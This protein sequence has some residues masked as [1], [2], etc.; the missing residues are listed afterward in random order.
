MTDPVHAPSE[1]SNTLTVNEEQYPEII[2]ILPI[3]NTVIFPSTMIPISVGRESS[4]KLIDE[5]ATG[6]RIVGCLFQ[7]D[8][9]INNPGPDDLFPIG[10]ICR[11]HKMFQVPSG[12]RNVVLQGLDRFR[13]VEYTGDDPYLSVRYELLPQEGEVDIATEAVINSI[14]QNAIKMINM[15]AGIPD[16]VAVIIQNITE[17]TALIDIIASN[18]NVS[19]ED[20][21]KILGEV[22]FKSRCNMINA[23][24]ARELEMAE[25][26]KKINDQVKHTIDK[27]QREYYLREPVSYTHLR[28][29]ET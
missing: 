28:A 3:R 17:S 2:P 5:T 14:R 16:E 25:L 24:L 1:N 29:H 18:L 12:E 27:T 13:V 20:K 23:M 9:D 26:T 6:V 22:D 7:K 15:S 19:V 4:K 8:P 21:I 11:I 10:S